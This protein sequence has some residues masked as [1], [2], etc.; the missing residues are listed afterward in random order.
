MAQWKRAGPITQRSEDQNLALLI[1]LFVILFFFFMTVTK[2]L[3]V[4]QLIIY[5]LF[6]RFHTFFLFIFVVSMTDVL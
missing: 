1:I 6:V 3:N 2:L 4:I 5:F